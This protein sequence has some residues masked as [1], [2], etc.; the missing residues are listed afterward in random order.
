VAWARELVRLND[1]RE[2]IGNADGAF[3]FETSAGFRYVADDAINGSATIKRNHT[4][5]Q[6]TLSLL[7][8]MLIHDVNYFLRTTPNSTNEER[9]KIMRSKIEKRNSDS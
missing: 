7:L 6:N 4:S 9:P 3:D 8:S 1:Q 5:L 2:I